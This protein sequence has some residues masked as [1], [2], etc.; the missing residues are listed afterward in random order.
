MKSHLNISLPSPGHLL[1]VLPSS[2]RYA[3]SGFHVSDQKFQMDLGPSWMTQPPK[4]VPFVRGFLLIIK[5]ME[6]RHGWDSLLNGDVTVYLLQFYSLWLL[7]PSQVPFVRCGHPARAPS[8]HHLGWKKAQRRAFL[9][10]QVSVLFRSRSR[11]AKSS[12]FHLSNGEITSVPLTGFMSTHWS[13]SDANSHF[14]YDLTAFLPV[15]AIWARSHHSLP[16]L[17]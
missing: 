14:K 16:L 13:G 4:E 6:E 1:I 5:Q 9:W 12:V 15:A 11:V 7:C 17:F 8:K 2:G 10:P 3:Q